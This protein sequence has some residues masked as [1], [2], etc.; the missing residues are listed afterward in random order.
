MRTVEEPDYFQL[1]SVYGRYRDV[2]VYYWNSSYVTWQVIGIRTNNLMWRR[3]RGLARF[4]FGTQLHEEPTFQNKFARAC[5]HQRNLR[6]VCL[7]AD[8]RARVGCV[9]R[10]IWGKVRKREF[11]RLKRE[12]R[13]EGA[14]SRTTNY[15]L[16][17][18]INCEIGNCTVFKFYRR[19]DSN[20]R[21]SHQT[22]AQRTL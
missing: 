6:N 14:E 22:G 16:Y 18:T 12:N 10:L 17:Q 3:R 11:F 5:S 13:T 2:C 19:W 15:Q 9:R 8:T 4:I 7:C 20:P 21:R 1:Q